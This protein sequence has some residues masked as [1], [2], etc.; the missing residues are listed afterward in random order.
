[1]LLFGLGCA[2]LAHGKTQINQHPVARLKLRAEQ[3]I[4][5][6]L[7]PDP[8]NIYGAICLVSLSNCTI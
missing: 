1:M 4:Y 7:P 8:G 5:L 2:D 3:Q 6:D